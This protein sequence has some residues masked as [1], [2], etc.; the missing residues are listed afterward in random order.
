[1]AKISAA[2]ARLPTTLPTTCG[3]G[4]GVVL[5]GELPPAPA[6]A[7]AGSAAVLVSPPAPMSP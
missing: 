1:M 6:V 2:P 5:P 3:V 4:S 7:R